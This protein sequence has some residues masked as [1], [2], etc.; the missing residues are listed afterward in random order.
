MRAHP[1]VSR[2]FAAITGVVLGFMVV[3]L[4]GA[5][6]EGLGKGW[7]FTSHGDGFL[8]ALLCLGALPA[9]GAVLMLR[10]QKHR[11]GR[12]VIL[13]LGAAEVAVLVLWAGWSLLAR[14]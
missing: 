10:L 3:A 12:A 2:T 14:T 1:A 9:A 4:L 8:V 7:Q 5:L 13:A 6:A 11:Q